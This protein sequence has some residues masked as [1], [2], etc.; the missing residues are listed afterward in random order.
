MLSFGLD[1][2]MEACRD[3]L[4]DHVAWSVALVKT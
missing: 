4:Q 3:T 1:M 2:S